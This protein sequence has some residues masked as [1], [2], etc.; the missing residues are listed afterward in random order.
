MKSKEFIDL[1]NKPIF[2]KNTI[3]L[4]L[5]IVLV[6]ALSYIFIEKYHHSKEVDISGTTIN[7]LERSRELLKQQLRIAR[8][9]YDTARSVAV[10]QD[11]D[12]Q[13]KDQLIFEKQKKIQNILNQEEVTKDDLEQA[14]RLIVSLRTELGEYQRQ[15]E[16]LRLQ[17]ERLQNK[18]NELTEENVLVHQ[19]NK[20]IAT[21]L[22]NVKAENETEK[23]A[24]NATL[25]ISNYSLIGLKIR[26]SGKEVETERAKRIDKIRVSFDVDANNNAL[27]ENKE[28]FVAIYKPDGSL[29]IFEDASSGKLPL[30][31]GQTIEFSDRVIFKY[32]AKK[33]NSIVFDWKDYN[34][35]K[36]EYK[37]DIYNNGFK[38]AQNKI[39]LK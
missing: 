18:N 20:A 33:S 7:E 31:S 24:V 13:Q 29:G 15:I 23:N 4:L 8:A 27:S 32:D 14:K 9:D 21:D 19:K 22:D 3:I 35:P 39:Y 1:E 16:V 25:S 26:N 28:L 38:I 17:N 6:G 10:T 34:F 30:R 11:Y 2:S 36:G 12:L 37:I 5:S